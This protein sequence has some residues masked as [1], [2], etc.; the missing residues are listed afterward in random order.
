[1]IDLKN[2]NIILTGGT[3][4]IGNAIIDKLISAGANV[5]ATGTITNNDKAAST[6]KASVDSPSITETDTG[7]KT[8]AYTITLDQ[9]A[10]E[11][12]T[13][14]YQTLTSGSAT[15]GEDFVTAAGVVTFVKG[16]KVAT[17]NISVNGDADVESDE[18]IQVK[19]SGAALSSE[20]IA[21]GTIKNFVDT[22]TT[23]ITPTT[24]TY[25]ILPSSS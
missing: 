7:T 2:L 8:L 20:V 5:I 18:T 11:T 15:T 19:F 12:T 14:N 24:P 9:E 3:G 4:V 17:L 23:P 13:I 10:K 16:Q 21:T 25:S 1:M 22:S 6:Y